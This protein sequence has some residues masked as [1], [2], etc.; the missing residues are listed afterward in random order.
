MGD[1]FEARFADAKSTVT[2]LG[3]DAVKECNALAPALEAKLQKT[4]AELSDLVSTT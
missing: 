2:Q 3:I 1:Q 4:S